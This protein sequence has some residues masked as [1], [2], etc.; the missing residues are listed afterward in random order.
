MRKILIAL[1]EDLLVEIDEGAKAN[2]MSRTE[3]IR[4]V[5][6]EEIGGTYPEKIREIRLEDPA[7]F[8]DLDD[9]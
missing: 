8:A 6:K 3:Y 9:S 4:Q 5:L 1:P 2:V 7:R